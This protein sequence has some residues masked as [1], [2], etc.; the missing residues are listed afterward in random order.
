MLARWAGWG[1]LPGVFD[2]ADEQWSEIRH[3]LRDLLDEAAWEAARR[4]TINAHYTSAEVVQAIWGAV[5]ALGFS[6]GRVLEPGCGSG[7]FIGL[8]PTD[9][10]M[11]MVGVELDPTTARIAAALYPHARIRSEGF[12]RTRFPP[13][14]F[15]LTV[16]NVP[17]GKIT[18]HDPVGN[19]GRHSIHNHFILKALSLTRPGGLVAVVT[20]RFTLDAR[21]PAARRE[22]AEMA[23]LL[24][25][26][27]LP[28]G[29]FRAAAGTDA[30]TDVLLLRRREPESDSTRGAGSEAWEST[31]LVTTPDGECWINEFL[32]SHPEMVL[33]ELSATRGQYSDA[34]LTVRARPGP[35]A[36]QLNDAL[37]SIVARATAA[38]LVWSGGHR[39]SDPELPTASVSVAAHHQEGSIVASREGGFA[40]IVSGEPRRFEVT[41]RQDR[42]ELAALLELRDVMVSL[43]EAQ[44]STADD[45]RF[46]AAQS[47]LNKRYDNYFARF[48]AL[49]RFSL[50]RTGRVD[51]QTGVDSYRRLRPAMGGFR[52]DPAFHSVMALEVFDPDTQTASKTPVFSERVVGPRAPRRGAESAQ[53]ALAICL[54][55][56]GHPDL[57]VIAGLLGV[58]EPTARAELGELVWND[59][60]SQSLVAAPN[61]L[62]GNV[63]SKLVQAEAAAAGDQRWMPNVEALRRVLPADL[64]PQDID[65]R[66]GAPWISADEVEAFVA[67]VLGCSSVVVDH[68]PVTATWAVSVPSW[69][70]QTVAVTSQWGTSRADAVALLLS[71]LN[72]RPATV[73]DALDDGGRILNAAETLA[74][75]EKQQAIEARFGTW[76]WEEPGRA[77]RLSARYNELFN[78]IALPSYDGSHLS[79][80]GLAHSF[81]AHPHQRD[82]V[83]RILQEPTTLLAHA[84][85]AG[86]TATMVMAGMELRRLGLANRPAY[87]VPNHM[88]DQFA[89]E[90]LQLYPQARVLVASRAEASRAG[91]KS[92]V[93][94]CATGD[95]DAVVLT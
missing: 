38:G 33:G 75:R 52:L 57:E 18:L 59:P 69:Q 22:M 29:A 43:L 41:P 88:L 24:G 91:R 37:A 31:T 5:T 13:G 93:A 54:D 19:A 76:V 56:H 30:V 67:E 81:R 27:R 7:N 71:S 20:S 16:G 61:Y 77:R 15:D 39:T 92:F 34:D 90:M 48:G 74:A 2:D 51:P 4:T 1:A 36:P 25:A 45:G 94:R 17:F 63:R 35:L 66:L 89:A 50:A 60:V 58:D 40:H 82:A 42:R 49:N 86:K 65:V 32:A 73:Y 23:E 83:W 26:V 53:D 11:E 44:A 84:V 55:D 9:V 85:G 28:A 8:A 47:L 6:G 87:V 68:A 46:T 64:E 3:R 14:S 70:R 95:W 62:S 21:N 78:S 79:T 80:P 12:E 72:Q 10:P